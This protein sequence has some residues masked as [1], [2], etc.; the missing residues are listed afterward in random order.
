MQTLNAQSFNSTEK[1]LVGKYDLEI[2]TLPRT[3]VENVDISQSKTTTVEVTQPGI[4][5][6][7][8]NGPGYGSIYWEDNGN[9]RWIYNLDTNSNRES[10]VLQ[11]GKYRVV[12]RPK[13]S[14]ESIYTLTKSFEVISGN[15]VA[16]PMN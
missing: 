3:Y 13:A 14:K 9:L 11:P 7:I 16:V 6:F 10:V 5:S 4:A 2:L 12:F 15:S 1:Y 8:Y